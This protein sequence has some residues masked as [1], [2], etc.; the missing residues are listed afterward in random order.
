MQ[1]LK[2]WIFDIKKPI[3]M[4]PKPQYSLENFIKISKKLLV[5]QKQIHYLW[6]FRINR[7]QSMPKMSRNHPVLEKQIGMVNADW[8]QLKGE[9][10]RDLIPFNEQRQSI[11][12]KTTLK[13]I[14]HVNY[15]RAPEMFVTPAAPNRSFCMCIWIAETKT[16][17]EKRKIN[18][19]KNQIQICMH[20][21][22][23]RVEIL[24]YFIKLLL[25]FVV[26]VEFDSSL[27]FVGPFDRFIR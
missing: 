26:I 7:Q 21:P 3:K 24:L 18:L 22:G 17:L 11:P 4:H 2:N 10:R 9:K 12:R 8:Y 6:S 1:W 13:M 14:L 27:Y 16:I 20:Q 15:Y 25:V 5:F 19:K 23:I